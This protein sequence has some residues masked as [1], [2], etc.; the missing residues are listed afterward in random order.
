MLTEGDSRKHLN[1]GCKIKTK[2]KLR[3][4]CKFEK[5]KRQN[6]RRYL[7]TRLIVQSQRVK[8]DAD[9]QYFL[10]QSVSILYII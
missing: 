10:F 8:A 2:L 4:T 7:I 1:T 9:S 3:L 5:S 6:E